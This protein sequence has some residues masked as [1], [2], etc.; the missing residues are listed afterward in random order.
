MP[1]YLTAKT[2]A[3]ESL[4]EIGAFPPSQSQ[5]DAGELRVSLS[6]LELILNDM[7]GSRT[8]AGLWDVIEIPLEAGK[9]EYDL[10]DYADADHVEHVFSIVLVNGNGHVDPITFGFENEAER[11]NRETNGTPNR[12]VVNSNVKPTITV[13]PKPTQADEDDEKYLRVRVQTYAAAVDWKGV[14]NRDVKLRPS[15]YW[16]AITKNAYAIGRGPVRRLNEQELKRLQDD[17]NTLE[18]RLLAFDGQPSTGQPPLTE[19]SDL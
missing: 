3:E 4:R 17:Y 12:A 15:W 2:L 7:A 18:N 5:A 10:E 14:A 13:F 9:A 16:W 1:N 8:F 6:R 11:E 19:S